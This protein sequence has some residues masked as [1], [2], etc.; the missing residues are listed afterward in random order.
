MNL[1]AE[2]LRKAAYYIGDGEVCSDTA[3]ATVHGMFDVGR[4]STFSGDLGRVLVAI[5]DELDELDDKAARRRS[6]IVKLESTIAERNRELRELRG[7]VPTEREREIL[8]MWPRFEGGEPVMIG[9]GVDSLGGEIIE[10]Y[11]A[12]NAAA[13]WNNCGNHMHLS[14]GERVKR[15]ARSV[16]DADGVE[17]RVGDTVWHED[18]T[19]LVVIAFG[20]FQDGETMLDVEYVAGPTEWDEVRCLSVT[21]TRPDSWERLEEDAAKGLCEYFG[22]EGRRCDAG[23]GC[24]AYERDSC[25]VHKAEDIIRRAKALAGVEVDE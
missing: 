10:V 3:I 4:A 21:H 5:A 14:L 19:E 2:K 15:P 9:D 23:E 12:G 1:T 13:I 16:P 18:G 24:P 6:H 25:A 8:D 11:I 20:D 17:I 22:F 7:Q